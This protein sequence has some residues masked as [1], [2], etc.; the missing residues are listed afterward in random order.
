MQMSGGISNKSIIN[1]SENLMMKDWCPYFL[2]DKYKMYINST[3][4]FLEVGSLVFQH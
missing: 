1:C 2:I 3:Y 4:Y